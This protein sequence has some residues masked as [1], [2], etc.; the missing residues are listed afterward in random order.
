MNAISNTR[1]IS[2]LLLKGRADKGRIVVQKPGKECVQGRWRG[3]HHDVKA[4]GGRQA[5]RRSVR[6]SYK[7]SWRHLMRALLEVKGRQLSGD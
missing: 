4:Y 3:I 2:V 6:F 5:L 1:E 7:K